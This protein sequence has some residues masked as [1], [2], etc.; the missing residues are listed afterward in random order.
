MS[1]PDKHLLFHGGVHPEQQK[2]FSLHGGIK[3][4]PLLDKYI[5]ILHQNIGAPPRLIVKKGDIVK[6]GQM[7]AESGGFVSAP[8]HS[9]T[10]GTLSD[11]LEWPGPA[12]TPMPAV[13]ITSDGNDEW[14][15]NLKPYPEWEEMR[16]EQLLNRIG[17]A[18]LVGMG[19]AAFPTF[20]K[21]SPPPA[22][23]IDTIILNGSECEPYLT[24]DHRLMLEYPESVIE[25]AMIFAK[26]LGVKQIFIGIENNKPDAIAALKSAGADKY[27]IKIMGLRVRYPQGAEKQLIYA[28]TGRKVPAGGL[29]MDVGCLV[30][31]VGTAAATVAAV[32]KGEPLIERITTVTGKPVCNP[33]NWK[34][35]IGTPISKAL[36]LAGGIKEETAKLLLGGPMM[37]LAQ[38][39]LDVPV[40]KSSSGILLLGREEIT[41]FTSEPCIHCGR[42][43]D[44]CPM[45]MMPGTLSVMVE[46]ERYD[47]AEQA[48][49]TDCMECGSCAYVCPSRRPLIQHFKRA[50]AEITAKKERKK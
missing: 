35:R 17:E 41:Q 33:G 16:P 21:L 3:T 46:N 13:E 34:F 10:S 36:E 5:V 9:P 6:K 43:V 27:R 19:G 50:K 18:G 26:I 48:N 30:Q 11:L 39:S 28:L 38:L 1:A 8:V 45:D 7:L 15:A 23:R 24:A 49:V 29:P 37:G 22:K 20:V 12:G 31:N 25:G 2:E 32:R 44:A 42:C 40:M 14:G 4:A 47:L